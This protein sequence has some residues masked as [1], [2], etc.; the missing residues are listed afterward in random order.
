MNGPLPQ[1]L[2]TLLRMPSVGGDDPLVTSVT[3]DSGSGL[4]A[5]S[6][7][8]EVEEKRLV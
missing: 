2:R 7:Q 3:T 6:R 4:L 5:N 8:D 1:V